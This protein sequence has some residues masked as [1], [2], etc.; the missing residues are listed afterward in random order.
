MT[1]LRERGKGKKGKLEAWKRESH[2][3]R[4]LLF[5]SSDTGEV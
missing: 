5:L 1:F 4:R 2:T 3:A